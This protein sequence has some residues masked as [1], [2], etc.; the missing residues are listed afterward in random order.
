MLQQLTPPSELAID[1]N[2]ALAHLCI[3]GTSEYD[4]VTELINAAQNYIETAITGGITLVNT[5]WLEVLPYFDQFSQLPN[6]E[7]LWVQYN[8]TSYRYPTSCSISLPKPPHI[9]VDSI[10]YYDADN[11]QQTLATDQYYVLLPYRQPATVQPV[12][13]W[14]ATYCR[15]DAVQ[16]TFTAGFSTV[17]P[18]LKHAILLLI[19]EWDRHRGDTS[20]SGATAD[21]V[22]RLIC[23]FHWGCYA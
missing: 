17:P 8:T 4:R 5:Q 21:A 16:I 20:V 15:P 10:T 7:S 13:T 11:V 22:E 1:L 19:A 9:S 14:P 12:T 6:R 18:A 3:D 2:T 23:P